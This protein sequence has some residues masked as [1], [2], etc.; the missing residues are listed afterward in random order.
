MEQHQQQAGLVFST[1]RLAAVTDRVCLRVKV[2]E[3]QLTRGLEEEMQLQA[4]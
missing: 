2:E 1:T 4:P 3:E